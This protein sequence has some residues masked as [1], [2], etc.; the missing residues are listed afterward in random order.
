M[1]SCCV[2]AA[3]VLAS[4]SHARGYTELSPGSF[5]EFVEGNEYS[6]VVFYAP[7]AESWEKFEDQFEEIDE[8]MQGSPIQLGLVDIEEHIELSTESGKHTLA[9][10]FFFRDRVQNP[11]IVYFDAYY[12]ERVMSFVQ[13]VMDSLIDT[14]MTGLEEI[15]EAFMKEAMYTAV[16][17]KEKGDV[18]KAKITA[19]I[20]AE[21]VA[22]KKRILGLHL[23]VMDAIM[24][25]TGNL[26]RNLH[27]LK[28]KLAN[29]GHHMKI[30]EYT[31][32]KNEVDVYTMYGEALLPDNLKK[33]NNAKAAKFE[34][35]KREIDVD[36]G[37][38][39]NILF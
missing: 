35:E 11:P 21:P 13:T 34:P 39:Q 1:R 4:L 37:G 5:H 16:M 29:H 10:K 3:C 28:E 31:A 14:Q 19:M 8:K 38:R 33:K 15:A 30:Q 2:I 36:A 7:W 18:H 23:R 12:A 32:L 25:M 24:M 20:E 9:I 17:E 27:S 6:L 22:Q 26:S